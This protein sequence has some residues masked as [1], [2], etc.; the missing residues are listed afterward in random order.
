LTGTGRQYKDN[1]CVDCHS[2]IGIESIRCRM[3][4]LKRV[5]SKGNERPRLSW[6]ERIEWPEPEQV[7]AMILHHGNN[8]TQVGRKLGISDNAI[9]KFLRR[10]GIDPKSIRNKL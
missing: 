2:K 1:F 10:N 6:E 7:V 4:N 9:R 8:F 3:C 5:D